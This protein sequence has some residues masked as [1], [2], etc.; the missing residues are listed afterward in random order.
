MDQPSCSPDGSL[1]L[2]QLTSV[3]LALLALTL[4]AWFV[5]GM[6]PQPHA[7]EAQTDTRLAQA[8][9]R[10]V[11]QSLDELRMIE[12]RVREL[13][14][15]VLPATVSVQAGSASGSGVVVSKDGYVLTAGHVGVS[16][17]RQVLVIFP[18]G[19]RVQGIT[20]GINTRMDSGLIKITEEGEWPHV[21][22][23]ASF[24]LKPGA[25]CLA[26]GH[27]GGFDRNRPGVVRL[28]RIIRSDSTVI[29]TDCTLVGG[30]SGGPLFD[31]DG[32]VIGIH[33]RIANPTAAN[34]H[35]PIDTYQLTWDRLVKGD[36]WGTP[37]P[38]G[39]FLGV[40]GTDHPK[41]CRLTQVM[42]GTPAWEAGLRPGDVVIRAGGESFEGY[43]AF[44]EIIGRTRPGDTLNV[45]IERGNGKAMLPVVVGARP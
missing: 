12:R 13:A 41:G 10:P 19:K 1:A 3:G 28:G 45:Q 39:P 14:E 9:S 32:R 38:G 15:R 29:Q 5:P 24:D 30:D 35:V 40:N 25:W 11:P 43:A 7:A 44:V 26:T 21:E 2:P 36:A 22:M 8:L 34:F 27:P 23:A 18:D 16:P 33:S 4:L 31:M 37:D 42:E 6:P 20:L 17:G